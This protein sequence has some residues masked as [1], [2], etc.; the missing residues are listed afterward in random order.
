MVPSRAHIWSASSAA[1]LY[2]LYRYPRCIWVFIRLKS[3]LYPVLQELQVIQ[4]NHVV[5]WSS[6]GSNLVCICSAAGLYQQYRYPRCIWVFTGL[7]PGLYLQCCR[8]LSTIQVPTL[9]MGLPRAQTWSVSA[10]LQ[11][12]TSYS[13]Q[14]PTLYLGLHRAQTWSASSAPRLYLQYR[15]PSCIWVLAELNLV[16]IQ[17]CRTLPAIQVPTLYLGLHRAQTWSVSSAAG[18][19][20]LYRYP[21]CIWV[22]ADLKHGLYPSAVGLY[23]QYRHP[24]CIWILAEMKPGLYPVLQA[25]TGLYQLY[26]YPRCIW[27]TQGSNLVCIQCCRALSAMR[28]LVVPK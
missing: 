19:Y 28:C 18:L 9:Y 11:D 23:Q 13:I 14:V 25:A 5:F 2:Q 27:F 7:K 17:C 21:R 6:Q 22:L 8:T 20:L 1:G 12:S 16:C 10:V 4:V 3:G 26:R 15:Y 24:R